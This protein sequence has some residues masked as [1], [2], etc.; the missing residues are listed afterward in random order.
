M[1]SVFQN[2]PARPTSAKPGRAGT[3]DSRVSADSDTALSK[4]ES[5]WKEKIHSKLLT[6][7]DLSLIG[8]MER[9]E[10]RKQIRDICQRLMQDES[11]LLNA[12]QR[13]RV[14]QR[15]EDEVLGLGPLELLLKVSTI[16]DILVNGA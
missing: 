6:V 1:A 4:L 14:I 5:E 13:T 11:A 7:M 9:L 3:S 16:S 8:S 12:D 2:R 15:I 10:A